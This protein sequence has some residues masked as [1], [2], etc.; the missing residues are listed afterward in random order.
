ML[1]K[2]LWAAAVIAALASAAAAQPPIY[3]PYGAWRGRI[4]YVEGPR[5]VRTRI[6]WGSGI[7]P[8]GGQVLMHL[9]TVAGDVATDPNFLSAVAGRDS[10]LDPALV[11][12]ID[13]VD[14]RNDSLRSELNRVLVQQGL[15]LVPDFV[16][17]AANLPA[18]VA[19][20]TPAT[21]QVTTIV[22][23]ANQIR[24]RINQLAPQI[25]NLRQ[26]SF[27]N[28]QQAIKIGDALAAGLTEPQKRTLDDLRN[29][30]GKMGVVSGL[31][32]PP[33]VPVVDM[34]TAAKFDEHAKRA[35]EALAQLKNPLTRASQDIRNLLADPSEDPDGFYAALLA[36]IG[37]WSRELKD[38]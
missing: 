9:A 26:D 30:V 31:Q 3:E 12:A 13:A 28:V 16:S 18:T 32:S 7:T 38:R 5:R 2:L 8:V 6:H 35:M 4:R 34:P 20:G 33:P 23:S 29:N 36:D 19:P 21:P 10:E 24:A 37:K 25:K 14:L 1:G 17:S 27:V 22:P 11:Q 15:A